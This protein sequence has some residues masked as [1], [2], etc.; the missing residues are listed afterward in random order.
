MDREILI[1]KLFLEKCGVQKV[2]FVCRPR[3]GFVSFFGS[4]FLGRVSGNTAATGHV[5]T[6]GRERTQAPVHYALTSR[7]SVSPQQK[8]GAVRLATHF[9][10]G[11]DSCTC[12]YA[13]REL[14]NTVSG[15]LSGGRKEPNL[16]AST[17]RTP[18]V[19]TLHHL[20]LHTGEW[21]MLHAQSK[22]STMVEDT[23]VL[24]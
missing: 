6:H 10:F 24:L 8:V 14:K 15:M 13:K 23:A 12:V 19:S 16:A 20:C 5:A 9:F 7:L 17:M 11:L 22:V 18:M 2:W 3:Q 4:V 21:A 1:K